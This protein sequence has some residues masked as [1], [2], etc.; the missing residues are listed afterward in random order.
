ME[1]EKRREQ[2]RDFGVFY[3]DNYNYLQHLKEALGPTELMVTNPPNTT[4]QP[5]HLHDEDEQSEEEEEEEGDTDKAPPVSLRLRPHCY[6][7]TL[8]PVATVT[9]AVKTTQQKC[10]VNEEAHVLFLIGCYQSHD[11]T[12]S[13]TQ[14]MCVVT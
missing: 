3:D 9:S 4:T 11:S 7:L 5:V 1:A 13:E 10:D 12:T 8:I 6:V 14:D 2:Q